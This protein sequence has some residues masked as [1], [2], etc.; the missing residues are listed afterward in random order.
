M[1]WLFPL[2]SIIVGLV[3]G[4]LG[5]YIGIR[6]GLVRLEMKMEA[7]IKRTDRH[8]DDLHDHGGDLLIHDL[9]INE[10]MRKLA[11]PR[12]VRQRKRERPV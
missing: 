4:W 7:V 12:M 11:M 1:E 10:I 6:I 2:I 9:E 8:H 5:A 3:S